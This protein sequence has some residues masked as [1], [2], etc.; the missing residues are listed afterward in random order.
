MAAKI[1]YTAFYEITIQAF[2][3]EVV[4]SGV[5]WVAIKAV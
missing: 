4:S 1:K 3:G 2:R 5:F